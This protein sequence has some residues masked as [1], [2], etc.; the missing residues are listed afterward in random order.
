M[1]KS[2]GSIA[3]SWDDRCSYVKPKSSFTKIRGWYK[4]ILYLWGKKSR[5]NKV[6]KRREHLRERFWIN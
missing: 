6:K 1:S 3:R 4:L 5:D 2:L